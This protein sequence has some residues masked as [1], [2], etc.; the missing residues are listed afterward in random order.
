MRDD[1]VKTGESVAFLESV[2]EQE[3]KGNGML[4]ARVVEGETVKGYPTCKQRVLETWPVNSLWTEFLMEMSIDDSE[5]T[6][7]AQQLRTFY[8]SRGWEEGT[9]SKAAFMALL[10]LWYYGMPAKKVCNQVAFDGCLS[11]SSQ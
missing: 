8:A 9:R 2:L 6:T 3:Q 4:T 1:L 11:N 5:A 10:Q 7:A